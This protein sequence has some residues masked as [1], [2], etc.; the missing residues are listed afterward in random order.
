MLEPDAIPNGPL[1]PDQLI[2][3][4]AAYPAR[5]H[6]RGESVRHQ[7]AAQ[8]FCFCPHAKERTQSLMFSNNGGEVTKLA[9][10]VRS[11]RG[12]IQIHKI[13]VLASRA[14]VGIE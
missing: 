4:F 6:P 11:K 7:S 1:Q 5:K 2:K 9:R 8:H 3:G 10:Y 12:R 14:I 13:M